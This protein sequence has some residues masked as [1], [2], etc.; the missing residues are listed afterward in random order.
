MLSGFGDLS[1]EATLEGATLNR[2]QVEKKD[3]N[4]SLKLNFFLNKFH[5]E[6]SNFEKE[7]TLS[8]ENVAAKT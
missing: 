3:E 8:S 2:S 6:V 4:L 1:G 5:F 7:Q